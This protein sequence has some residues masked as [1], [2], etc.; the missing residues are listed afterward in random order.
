[1]RISRS[2]TMLSLV[3][4]AASLCSAA[5]ITYGVSQTVGPGSLTGF[6]ETDGTIGAI[7][8]SNILD[9]NLLLNDGT[10]TVNDHRSNSVFEVIGSDLSATTT[11][12]L[13]NFSG[14]D[15]GLVIFER[16]GFVGANFWC[17]VTAS[18]GGVCD[19]APVAGEEVLQV[20]GPLFT[21]PLSG[22]QAIAS[23][24]TPTP[25]RQSLPL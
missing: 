20:T 13:F 14:S 19:T 9:F 17:A 6:I 23:A 3:L 15:F 4:G 16:G 24:T 25:T 8:T 7:G 18:A 5:T 12:L 11:Q 2:L 1:M 10:T 22:T 21:S